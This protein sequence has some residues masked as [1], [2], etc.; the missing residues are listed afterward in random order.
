MIESLLLIIFFIVGGLAVLLAIF[1]FVIV[2]IRKSKSMLYLG[3]GL[4][5]IP[6][7]LYGLTFWFYDI[8]LPKQYK[9]EEINYLGTYELQNFQPNKNFRLTL[10]SNNIFEIDN[11]K[12]LNFSG[13]GIWK[14]GQTDDGQLTFYDNDKSIVFWAWPFHNNR[15]E[16]EQ[17]NI[18]FKFVKIE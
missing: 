6:L 2:V 13:K 14:A 16:I 4:S 9:Q 7:F 8:H 15:I 11:I 10:Y 12:D 3:L 1:F 18:T 5:I 17:N